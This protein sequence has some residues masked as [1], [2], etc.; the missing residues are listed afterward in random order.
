MPVVNL[1]DLPSWLWVVVIGF[2]VIFLLSNPVGW[3]I[4]GAGFV[5][6][7]IYFAIDISR[8]IT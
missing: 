6:G 4:M 3:T 8:K 1:P 7:A 5:V 2:G